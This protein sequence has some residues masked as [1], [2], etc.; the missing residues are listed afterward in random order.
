MSLI[1]HNT[2]ESILMSSEAHGRGQTQLSRLYTP[3]LK[4]QGHSKLLNSRGLGF[5]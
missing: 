5:T 3:V 4:G 1:H 2:R